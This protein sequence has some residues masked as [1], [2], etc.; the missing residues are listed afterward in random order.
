MERIC[1]RIKNTRTGYIAVYTLC[2][3][4]LSLIVFRY[5][6]MYAKTTILVGDGISQ[7]YN[8]LL[9]YSK[10]LRQILSTLIHEHRLEFPMWDISAGL[11]EDILGVMHYYGVGEPIMLLAAFVPPSR[12]DY[13]YCFIYIA[14]LYLG[15]LGFSWFSL[16]HGNRKFA[17]L[18]GAFVYVFSGYSLTLAMKH[19]MFGVPIVFFPL[20]L[21]GVDKVIR[22]RSCTLF[23]LASAFAALSNIYFFYAQM[24]FAFIY[25]IFRLVCERR[26][27]DFKQYAVTL[28]SF[29]LSAAAIL[30]ISA[31]VLLP[32][33]ALLLSESRV[34][35]G[36]PYTLTYG[37]KYYFEYIA[38]FTN[39]QQ[40]EGL[41][42]AGY[43][44]IALMAV[45]I[46]FL[47]K[48]QDFRLKAAVASFFVFSFVP[49]FAYMMNGFSYVTNRWVWAFACLMGY[50]VAKV[51]PDIYELDNKQ[52]LQGIGAVLVICALSVLLPP[53]RNM[54]TFAS[55]IVLL[56]SCLLLAAFDIRQGESLRSRLVVTAV[57]VL[58]LL[59][60]TYRLWSPRFD[61]DGKYVIGKY[62]D[63]NTADDILENR[64]SDA[65]IELIGDDEFFRT[66]E[67]GVTTG[68]GNSALH[69][70]VNL[71]R[72]YFS[73]MLP[74]ISEF[75]RE[76]GF[77]TQMDFKL[78]GTDKRSIMD[79][80]LSVRY[81]NVRQGEED[82][83]PFG[84]DVKVSE[85]D[86]YDG[87]SA[88]WKNEHYLP[89]G[90]TYDQAVSR[91]ELY[92]LD[93]AGRQEAMLYGAVLEP[94]AAKA[95]GIPVIQAKDRL[96]RRSVLKG[97]TQV[98]G[99]ETVITDKGIELRGRDAILKLEL[100]GL[101]ESEN[102]VVLSGAD[103]EGWKMT[104]AYST[105]EWKGLSRY[106]RAGIRAA[107]FLKRPDD[108]ATMYFGLQNGDFTNRIE[109]FTPMHDCYTG[110]D[111]FITN[112]GYSRE[113]LKEIYCKLTKPGFYKFEKLDVV[114]QPTENIT[115]R[116][117]EL[118]KEPL[119]EVSFGNNRISGRLKASKNRLL[120]LSIPYSPGWR[121]FVDGSETRTACANLMFLSIPVSSGEHS[122][123]LRYETPYLR[124]GA[125]LS[126]AGFAMLI[127]MMLIQ[128]YLRKK[129][130]K[131]E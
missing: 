61:G 5:F 58:G 64:N 107:D 116:L 127:A 25:C 71:C 67:I 4:L 14:R 47:K 22:D 11:G 97:I 88:A 6:L 26:R 27:F 98:S 2:F 46:L 57:F 94:E 73:M 19:L 44:A 20:I 120:V 70:S 9:Y 8:T 3:A 29:A 101:P 117:D 63:I 15:G 59:I 48:N 80:L 129:S 81:Y 112:L 131:E 50:V 36:Y 30:L 55:I 10:I 92:S 37:L 111:S 65:A 69:R 1:G 104:S 106:E 128:G 38:G 31:V 54:H 126:A 121:A 16:W 102:Y 33:A 89:L 62:N 35:R 49:Y 90:Y 21:L 87:H 51:Y 123:E 53:L 108:E 113:G 77:N 82:S 45:I 32:E 110:H 118:R 18:L 99:G 86:T 28:L 42:T 100:E 122:I 85:A 12:T 72:R 39:L 52:K 93:L 60:M 91:E 95:G 7:N 96:E 84:Y 66:G 34:G 75:I 40:A 74:N 78:E 119:E 24:V 23:I 83:L 68:G 130:K 79:A 43:S 13:L 125:Y 124:T 41:M 114:C 76:L 115:A 105:D 103:F 109:Y 17:T 56:L